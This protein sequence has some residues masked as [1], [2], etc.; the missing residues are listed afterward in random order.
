MTCCDGWDYGEPVGECPVCGEP[1]DED[2]DAV[3]GCNYSPIGCEV[4]GSRP[5]DE[6]C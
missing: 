2:G 1:V 5:C 3:I 6:S 4:C